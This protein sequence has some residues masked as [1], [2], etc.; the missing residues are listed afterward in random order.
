MNDENLIPLSKRNQREKEKIQKM[1]AKAAGKS[2]RKR[3][4][5]QQ[6]QKSL[7]EILRNIV[8]AEAQTQSSKDLLKV[9]G[10]TDTNYFA[11]LTASVMLKGIKKGDV[12]A[13]AKIMELLEK[14]NDVDETKDPLKKLSE[15]LKNG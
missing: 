7:A 4:E 10:S 1:G 13:M 5:E 2:H 15:A 6:Q 8:F 9:V 11:A 14:K 12:N 3:K